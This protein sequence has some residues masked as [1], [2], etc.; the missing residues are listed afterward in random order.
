MKTL[1]IAKDASSLAELA[2]KSDR[3]SLILTVKGKPVAVLL[4]VWNADVET[5]SLSF[6]PKFLEIIEQSRRSQ[7]RE[8]GISSEE[9]RRRFGLPPYVDR[10]PKSKR[11]KATA[12]KRTKKND[13]Q[14]RA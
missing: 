12:L 4:P 8:G 6:N 9:M 13:G 7:E 10:N 5:V 1:E 2:R 11:L 3:E 14:V